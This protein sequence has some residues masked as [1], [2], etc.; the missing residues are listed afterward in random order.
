[1]IGVWRAWAWARGRA[2][3]VKLSWLPG[4]LVIAIV[5]SQLLAPWPASADEKRMLKYPYS[6][7]MKASLRLIKIDL[8]C[9]IEE[10]DKDTG[11]IL[12]RYTYQG[13]E[14]PAS[15]EISDLSSDDNGYLV[16]SRV[17]MNELPS[18]VETD[19]LDKLEEKLKDEY[20]DPPKP[21]KKPEPPVKDEGEEEPGD[22]EKTGS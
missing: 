6:W 1:M 11:Y 17:M 4:I 14:S 13:V 21:K 2:G 10:V 20:G 5:A 18:W 8:G 16:N 3:R 15:L 12:F 19:L 9:P 22:E 7:V